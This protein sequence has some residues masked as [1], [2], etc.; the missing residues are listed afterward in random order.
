MSAM[1]VCNTTLATL[2]NWATWA[3]ILTF[4][5]AAVLWFASTVVKVDQKRFE[6][7]EMAAGRRWLSAAIVE[8]GV[9]FTETVKVQS[10]FNCWAAFATSLGVFFQAIAEA[11]K[12]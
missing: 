12:S 9:N 5:V 3:S 4:A 7:K 1:A 10:K 2:G 8:G 11:C 6:E